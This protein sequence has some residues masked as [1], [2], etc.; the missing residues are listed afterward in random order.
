MNLNR[1]I[2]QTRKGKPHLLINESEFSTVQTLIGL[3][4]GVGDRRLLNV[5]T[6]NTKTQQPRHVER[7]GK[8]QKEFSSSSSNSSSASSASQVEG[9]TREG[10]TL[11]EK[12]GETY[13]DL[14]KYSEYKQY[15]RLIPNKFQPY[16]F[17]SN[18]A[19]VLYQ[20]GGKKE[21]ERRLRT[22]L[23]LSFKY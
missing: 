21:V 15:L 1:C 17:Y 9:Y 22:R 3:Y 13:S 4:E 19:I 23:R 8:H 7:R 20:V 12:E 11:M 5:K 16:N 14:F 10:I 6:L 18:L 2:N